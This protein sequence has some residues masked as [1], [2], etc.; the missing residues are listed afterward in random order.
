MAV[1][2]E[3]SPVVMVSMTKVSVFL[4]NALQLCYA[5]PMQEYRYIIYITASNVSIGQ[6]HVNLMVPIITMYFIVKRN[7]VVLERLA[8]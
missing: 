2:L 1:I 3:H 8:I 4:F 5:N 6:Q 7:Y